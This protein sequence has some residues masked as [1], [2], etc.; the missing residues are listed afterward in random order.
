MSTQLP[1]FKYW[2]QRTLPQVYDDSLSHIEL[3]G[4]VTHHLNEVIDS[5][6]KTNDNV[7]YLLGW[8]DNL[9]VQDEVNA[10]L[11]VYAVDGT[12][13]N[14]INV[15]IFNDLNTKIAEHQTTIDL[16]NSLMTTENANWEV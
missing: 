15:K 1:N 11:D 8:F 14:I 5:Q 3:L 7:T 9:D 16:F 2:V 10:K 6:N 4:K 13:D 12:L